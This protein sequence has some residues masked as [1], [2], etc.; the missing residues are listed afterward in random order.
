MLYK[1]KDDN[2]NKQ[3]NHFV[4]PS[5]SLRCLIIGRSNCGKTSLL[6]KLLLENFIDFNDLFLYSKST[7][8][9]EYKLLK[10]AFDKGYNKSEI[11][12]LFSN[13]NGNIDEYLEN[14]PKKRQ[15]KCAIEYFENT[16]S[17]PDPSDIDPGRKNLF[18]FDDIATE[19]N[20]NPADSFYTRGR[21]NNCSSIYL[22]QNYHILPRQTIR[23]NSNLLI[24]FE[25]PFIDM[26]NIHSDYVAC[27]MPF[28][29]FQELCNETYKVPYSF[30]LI[31]KDEHPSSGKYF[32]NLNQLYIPQKYFSGN[33][34]RLSPEFSVKECSIRVNGR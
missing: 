13:G 30:V 34:S 29:E 25:L 17:V 11:I 23:T 3:K 26:K 9:P 18:I 16:A 32:K 20:Q 2:K 10:N 7:H 31:N 33:R 15:Q 4:F 8:Q 14:L 28:V 12:D 6:L 24:L 1:W 22:S 21:H 5:P 19:K 27:D